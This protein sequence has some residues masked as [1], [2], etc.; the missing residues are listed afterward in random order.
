MLY[1]GGK[2]MN[3]LWYITQKGG[4]TGI[5]SYM[6]E[7]FLC[8]DFTLKGLSD[9][10]DWEIIETENNLLTYGAEFVPE[11]SKFTLSTLIFAK[12]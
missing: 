12:K 4:K 7:W 11:P 3:E 8:D 6:A 10:T 2:G 5:L 9:Y 1:Q